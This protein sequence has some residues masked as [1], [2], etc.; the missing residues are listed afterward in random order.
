MKTQ[1][2]PL[3]TEKPLPCKMVGATGFEPTTPWSQARCSTK[4]SYAPILNLYKIYQNHKLVRLEGFEPPTHGLEGR[5]SIQLSYRRVKVVGATGFEPTTPWSQA[6]CSTK[7]SYAPTTQEI[8]CHISQP[9]SRKI[10]IFFF[11]KGPSQLFPAQHRL[12][13]QL[14]KANA[15]FFAKLKKKF[16]SHCKNYHAAKKLSYCK[17]FLTLQRFLTLQSFL[18]LPK[19]SDQHVSSSVADRLP[20]HPQAS[21]RCAAPPPCPQS[22]HRPA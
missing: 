19:P 15:S 20:W 10:F 21:Y 3:I 11:S 6:R 7:L 12:L 4:L 9:L 13:Y 14:S 2:R 16:F 22:A 17:I 5:C 8:L 1:K 18:T